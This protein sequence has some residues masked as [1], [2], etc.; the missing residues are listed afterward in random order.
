[1]K[2]IN[3]EIFYSPTDISNFEKCNFISVN[4]IKNL[5]SP[6]EIKETTEAL[7]EFINQGI[8][9]EKNYVQS[10]I[11]S[12]AKLFD[13][14]KIKPQERL[15][16]TVDAMKEGYD[17]IYHPLFEYENWVGEPDLLIK[18]NVP[19]A[20]GDYSY[21][22]A[23]IK[24]AKQ[25]KQENIT[26]VLSYCYL[27]EKSQS[28][29]PS[30][31]IIINGTDHIPHEFEV[32]QYYES[33][34][35][36]R[37]QFESFVQ[38]NDLLIPEPC[39]AC[40]FC[41]Y[42]P[43]CNSIWSDTH[44][45]NVTGITNRQIKKLKGLAGTV[46]DLANLA[47]TSVEGIG[48]ETLAKLKRQAQLQQEKVHTGSP[49]YLFREILHGKGFYRMPLA[50]DQ[51]IFFDLEGDPTAEGGH[52]YLFGYILRGEFT[53]VWSTDPDEEKQ[54]FQ[55]IM[56]FFKDHLLANPAAHIYHYNHYE[57][58]A[59]KR[60]TLKY[61]VCADILD[62]L[63]R[64]ESFIDLYPVVRESIITSEK[65]LSIKDLEIFYMPHRT[66]QVT[67]G[68]DSVDMFLKWKVNKDPQILHDIGEYNKEDCV[69]TEL[70]RNWLFE[71]QR[72]WQEQDNIED[73]Q[74]HTQPNPH[75]FHTEYDE[76]YVTTH[77]GVHEQTAADEYCRNLIADALEYHRREQKSEWWRFFAKEKFDYIELLEDMECIGDLRKITNLRGQDNR[78]Y[79]EYQYP[80]QEFKIKEGS[81]L[82]NI[83]GL[84]GIGTLEETNFNERRIVIKT[85]AKI[86]DL[87]D[88]IDVTSGKPIDPKN[89]RTALYRFA[90]SFINQESKY[91]NLL[92]LINRLPPSFSENFQLQSISNEN[93]IEGVKV[94]IEKLN[95]SY[96]FIQGPPGTGKTYVTAHAIVNLLQQG[97]RIAVTSNSHKAI[98]NVLEWIDRIA[99]EQNYA[100]TGIKK[101]SSQSR[102]SKYESDNM[103]SKSS[104][105]SLPDETQLLAA[106]KF[107]FSKE[108]YDSVFDY[109]FID[110]AGQ[111][112]I[113]DVIASGTCA[114]NLVLI[115][116][117]RQLGNPSDIIHPGD[118]GLS[119]LDYIL[120]DLNTVPLDLGVFLGITR[121]MRSEITPFISDSF[122]DARLQS[123]PSTNER[124]LIL[125]SNPLPAD[126]GI[127]MIEMDH[128]DNAQSS[129]EEISLIKKLYEYFRSQHYFD[130]EQERVIQ[131]EDMLVV[132]PYNVQVNLLQK[133]L[134]EGNRTGTIDKFQGQ[135]APISILSMTSSDGENAPRGIN[136]LM[137]EARL[138]VAIS[139]AQCLS[140]ILINKELFNAQ[141]NNIE[142]IKL[143][144]NFLK[145]RKYSKLMKAAAIF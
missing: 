137:E 10:L 132:A 14:S 33:Y 139:R 85:N 106:T 87:P 71:L 93:I 48:D 69:S 75:P 104:L 35:H 47:Q 109:L 5:T 41:Q 120:G 52:E 9:I 13:G 16:K 114:H 70:L 81:D 72:Q 58:T 19:S 20:L 100:Y 54:K 77:R 23:D 46:E 116:D 6:L 59:L 96:L 108:I 94:A 103:A 15:Q 113:P 133:N 43:T 112:A 12:E 82:T 11:D 78:T 22:P 107:E 128:A 110:E 91:S 143:K 83:D 89:L 24:R 45:K 42:L 129:Q 121:R 74:F 37:E 117:P 127:V 126:S 97:K 62:F 57:T 38:E 25:P 21:F 8:E 39:S 28:V 122:Y 40:Q 119:V 142:Q 56:E 1:M 86:T 65:G 123:H 98:N 144:N 68:A 3:K 32:A 111:L 36:L 99:N 30:K 50:N 2:Y 118:S 145:L 130:G 51:D 140:V 18:T 44:I 53:A 90:R 95:H 60:M 131:H 138:N 141:P 88:V 134:P 63:L 102:D 136:F 125:Q 26:Q 55:E 76:E 31:F 79:I 124:Y 92:Q 64:N 135:E 17:Y 49:K 67:S 34:T 115:G 27:L 29:L 7:K 101:Y 84:K 66:A 73:F 80:I 61:D 4:D 105:K